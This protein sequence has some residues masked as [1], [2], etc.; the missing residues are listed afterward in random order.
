MAQTKVDVYNN[1]LFLI[2]HTVKVNNPDEQTIEATNCKAVYDIHRRAIL[3]Q[4]NWGFAKTEIALS[5]TG[6]TPKGW[7]YEYH[8]PAKCLKVI[9][10]MR[11]SPLLPK[12]P[13]QIGSHYDAN[14]GEE[15]KTIWTNEAGAYAL[16]TRDTE[17]VD[18]FTPK[19]FDTLSSRVAVDL[20]RVMTTLVSI[21]DMWNMFTYNFS[22]AVR[23][24]EA[25]AED[26]PEK[27]SS[28]ITEAYGS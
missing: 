21:K 25:E 27:E 28:W 13:F 11:D 12:I 8:Y 22:E 23:V 5:L 4:A 6:N 2:G 16:F 20:A 15:I 14:T 3:T 7:A 17:I 10:L 18:L 26:E 24:G 19:F 9:E 1:S